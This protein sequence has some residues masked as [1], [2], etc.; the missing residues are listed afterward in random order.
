MNTTTITNSR[1]TD[2]HVG[3]DVV[4]AM[5]DIA[6]YEVDLHL[7]EHNCTE[8]IRRLIN[9]L[10][11]YKLTRILVEATGGY[12]RPLVEACVEAELPVIVVQPMQIHQFARTQGILAKTDMIDARLIAEFGVIMQPE[13]T[14]VCNKK[15]RY[16]KDLLAR[17]R[18]LNMARTQELNRSHKAVT[19]MKATHNRLI[20]VLDKEIEWVDTKLTKA[21]GEATEWQRLYKTLSSVPGVGDG[22][23]YALM[24]E[25]PELGSL[26]NSQVAALCGLAPFNRDSG[27]M[28]GKRRIR[29]GRLRSGPCSTW[30]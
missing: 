5:L 11:R 18:Q 10:K 16:I 23:A 30:R 4:K 21:V 6:T 15:V 17:K 20:K 13:I 27:T 1:S 2:R 3:I 25:L 12:E 22:V 28:R 24:R 9:K 19:A 7:Q 26:S 29:G 14:P 8:G